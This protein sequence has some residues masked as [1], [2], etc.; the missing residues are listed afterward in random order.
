MKKQ[1]LKYIICDTLAAMLAWTALFLFRKL[2]LEESGFGG[3]GQ[4]FHDA[5][6]WLGIVVVPIGWLALYTI[7]GTYRNVLR[8]ARLKE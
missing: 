1:T 5:N 6:Y 2:V 3:L 4:V 7:Q 8:K